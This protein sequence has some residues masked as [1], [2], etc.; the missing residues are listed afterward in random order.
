[1]SYLL[2]IWSDRCMLQSDRV[3]LT[4]SLVICSHT[5]VVNIYAQTKVALLNDQNQSRKS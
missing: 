3:G 4:V 5:Y 1:M 2:K